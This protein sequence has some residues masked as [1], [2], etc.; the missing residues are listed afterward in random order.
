M[1]LIPEG[2]SKADDRLFLEKL[3]VGDEK[4]FVIL[5]F[6][7]LGENVNSFNKFSSLCAYV[8]TCVISFFLSLL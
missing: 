8:S 4:L 5:C 1:L 7:I 3:L 2:E 6:D